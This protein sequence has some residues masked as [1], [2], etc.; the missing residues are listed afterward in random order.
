MPTTILIVDDEPVQRRLLESAV[1]K[2]GYRTI[3]AEDGDDAMAKLNPRSGQDVDLVVMDLV[4]PGLDGMGAL[5]RMRSEKIT[6]PVIVQT[7]R[8]SIDAVVSAMRAGACDFFVKP[9]SFERLSISIANALKLG[10]MEDAV[11]KVQKSS[12]GKFDFEDLIADSAA[13]DRVI[14]LGKRAADSTIPV[15]IE[16]ESGVGKEV[17]AKAIQ[18]SGGRRG[19]PFVTVNC[20]ALPENLVESI[21]FG[22]EK[23]SFTGASDSHAG[24]FVEAD[25]GTLFL[26][27]VGELSLDIQVK[28]L[29]AIQEGEVDPI[30][31]KR[32]RKT[33]FRLISATNRDMIEMVRQ[34]LFREDLYYRL[35]VFP[36]GVPPLR[37]RKS[38]IA[39]LVRYFTA[40][41]SLEQGR[42]NICG[43]RSDALAMLEAF[44]W[45]G[46]IRQ[47]ENAVYRA[48][49]LCEDD[50][51]KIE[52]FPHIEVEIKGFNT[53]PGKLSTDVVPIRGHAGGVGDE[54]SQS[55]DTDQFVGALDGTYLNLAGLDGQPR[56]LSELESDAIQSAIAHHE[57]RMT[58]VARSLGIGRS[59][60]YRKL[61]E[62]GLDENGEPA[63]AE[64]PQ[65]STEHCA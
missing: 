7:A 6:T 42:R 56:T 55:V 41:L 9:V 18:G 22:H 10:A 23:G 29:R 54:L 26:D 50:Q 57:G 13:M 38:D 4:M 65:V 43:I 5:G 1:N 52:D 64:K 19:K 33:D 45:P 60:L 32:P 15:L 46:N 48:I 63:R 58:K 31:S 25:G 12:S 8:G 44:D 49:I 61:K 3:L 40:R 24:K 34:G 11:Q 51:L 59:T 28:L 30:G 35:N 17:I 14:K 16:G 20:G 21:L 27:E 2:M 39:S 36:I 47:L 53:E 37:Q 62:Y